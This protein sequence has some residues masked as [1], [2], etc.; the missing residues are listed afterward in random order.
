MSEIFCIGL[1]FSLGVNQN[2]NEPKYQVFF[3]QIKIDAQLVEID[4]AWKAL[5]P[6]FKLLCSQVHHPDSYINLTFC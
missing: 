3:S 1:F 5:L 4:T 6:S 2:Q